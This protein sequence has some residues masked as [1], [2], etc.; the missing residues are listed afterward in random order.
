MFTEWGHAGSGLLGLERADLEWRLWG[1]E[2]FLVLGNSG[3][4]PSQCGFWHMHPPSPRPKA[5][6]MGSLL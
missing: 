1:T 3:Q 5:P 2:W 6:V 4:E